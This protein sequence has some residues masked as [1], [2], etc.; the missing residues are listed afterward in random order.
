MN[1]MHS[2]LSSKSYFMSKPLTSLGE[3]FLYVR[4]EGTRKHIMEKL[5]DV[6]ENKDLDHVIMD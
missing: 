4:R 2:D 6:F 5:E 1:Q 3:G